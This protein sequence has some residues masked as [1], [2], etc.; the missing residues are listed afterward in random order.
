ML[1]KKKNSILKKGSVDISSTGRHSRQKLSQ[2]GLETGTENGNSEARNVVSHRDKFYNGTQGTTRF[3]R[4]STGTRGATNS[5]RYT[6]P[7]TVP[8]GDTRTPTQSY[9]GKVQ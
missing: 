6:V 4:S 8:H 5:T 3:H 9:T 7:T 1:K 2:Y